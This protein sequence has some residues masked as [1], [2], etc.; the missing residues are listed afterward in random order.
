MNQEPI[1][2]TTAASPRPGAGTASGTAS[3]ADVRA[4]AAARLRAARLEALLGD[5]QDPAN[6]HG[7]AAL[8]AADALGEPPEPTEALLA[9][10]GLAAEFVP[11][12]SGGL[13]TRA[14]L[15]VTALR[16]LFRRDLALGLGLVSLSAAAPVWAAGGAR[17]QQGT[18]D[19][20]LRG[21]RVAAVHHEPAHAN[22]F[23]RGELTAVPDRDGWIL[24]GRKDLVMNASRADA[25]VACAR[26]APERGPRSRSLFLLDPDGLPPEGFRGLPRVPTSGL[27]GTPFSGLEF[28]RC[29]APPDALVGRPGEGTALL[30]RT[31]QID[32]CLVPA[33]AVAA[34]GTVLR[35][36]VRAATAGRTG[37]VARRWHK[38]LAGVFADLLT[39]DSM[40]TVALRALGLLPDR[41]HLL[42]AAVRYVVPDLLRENLEELATVL[43]VPGRAHDGPPHRFLDK[44]ARDLPF[45]SLGHTGTAACH[46]VLIPQLRP[47]A[48]RSWFRSAEPPPELFGTGAGLPAL[49]HRLLGVAGG[50]DLL[51]ASLVGSA[52]RLAAAPHADGR[53]AVLA[54]LAGAFTDELRTLRS[55]CAALPAVPGPAAVVLSDRYALLQAAA[56]VLGVWEGQDGTDAFLAEPAWAVLAL[57]RLARRLGI[58]A[59]GPPDGCVAQTLDEL[60]R[61]LRADRDCGL[62]GGPGH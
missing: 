39:C 47:L 11:A 12:R 1:T 48:E 30:L 19:L 42:A 60:V 45:A 17:Q 29:P 20:L 9:G 8:A 34:T 6:P 37:P 56:A 23:A 55:R 46:A 51:A 3:V 16:P 54:G 62:D 44:L 43:G 53:I 28:T 26:T 57:S 2:T 4:D 35:S 52:G 49:D 38:P 10:A 41:A 27:R 22:A 21:G 61:R 7:T 13:L 31:L 33:A 5:P 40:V 14:D 50:E 18:A 59:P 32:H 24:D 58:T 25:W 36:A 15:L